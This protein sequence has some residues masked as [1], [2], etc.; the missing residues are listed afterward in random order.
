MSIYGDYAAQIT[1]DQRAKDLRA[2][3]RRDS[4]ARRDG[5]VVQNGQAGPNAAK[6]RGRAAGGRTRA[7]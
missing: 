7:A 4:A 2:E 6:R 5:R 3:A 1:Q